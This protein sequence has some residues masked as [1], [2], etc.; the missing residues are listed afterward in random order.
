MDILQR[1]GGQLR[2]EIFGQ[3]L[4]Y[5]PRN[6][7]KQAFSVDIHDPKARTSM[8]LSLRGFQNTSVRKTLVGIFVA[9]SIIFSWQKPLQQRL[10]SA[11]WP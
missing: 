1:S 10:S 4:R 3:N 2:A 7:G 11:G 8:T 6:L 5:A 9:Y